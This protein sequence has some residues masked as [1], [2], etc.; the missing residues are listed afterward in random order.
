MQISSKVTPSPAKV[1]NIRLWAGQKVSS[2][3][4][5]VP[6]PSWLVTITN[7]KSSLLRIKPRLR[8]TLG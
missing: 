1:F 5:G 3:K 8:I 6:N 2:G 7:A 4:E